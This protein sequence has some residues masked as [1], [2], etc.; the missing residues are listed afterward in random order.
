MCNAAKEDVTRNKT[1][2]SQDN[3]RWLESVDRSMYSPLVRSA[4]QVVTII[5]YIPS[6]MRFRRAML[7]YTAT[8]L[9][10]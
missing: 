8:Q 3:T 10:D 2:M 6:H 4:S 9:L 5:E 7:N 1:I